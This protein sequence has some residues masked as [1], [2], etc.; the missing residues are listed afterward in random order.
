MAKRE[1]RQRID[2]SW[3]SRS[4]DDHPVSEL[5]ATLQGALPPYG[6]VT[7]PVSADELP[8]VHPVTE[9]NK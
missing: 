3:P 4:E 1:R 5:A 8:Y 9:I 6:E 2:P 7:F